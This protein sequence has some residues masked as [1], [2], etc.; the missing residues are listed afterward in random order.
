[1]LRK[2][3]FSP[4]NAGVWRLLLRT[5][6]HPLPPP[7]TWPWYVLALSSH[8]WLGSEFHA[9]AANSPF[10]PEVSLYPRT[11]PTSSSRRWCVVLMG[12]G[13]IS[14]RGLCW[15]QRR[16]PQQ[17]SWWR[18]VQR[19]S[20][21]HSLAYRNHLH[22]DRGYHFPT[23]VLMPVLP[24]LL[25][26]HTCGPSL[27]F[28]LSSQMTISLQVNYTCKGLSIFF[29]PWWWTSFSPQPVF[30]SHCPAQ[31]PVRVGRRRREGWLIRENR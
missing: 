24:I 7:R 26:T 5:S 23:I 9:S 29:K 18:S 28:F 3:S 12:L 25:Q 20:G 31:L 6:S 2:N 14:D 17:N 8:C 4:R 30:L 22:E 19:L 27:A 13:F 16:F 10:L 15:V 21:C 11:L 1:M